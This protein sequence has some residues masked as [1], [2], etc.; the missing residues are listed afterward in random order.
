[1]LRKLAKI[2]GWIFVT[3]IVLIVILLIYVRSVATVDPPVPASL[4]ILDAKV[5]QPD[6]GL[7]TIGNNWFRKSESGLYE[8]YVEGTPFERGVV[9]GKLTH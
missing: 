1:M 9:N 3:L 2:I 4:A 5:E 6:S 7:Y 8:L